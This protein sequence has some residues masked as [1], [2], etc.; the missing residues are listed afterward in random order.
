MNVI[1]FKRDLRVEDN[2]ALNAALSGVGNCL[3]LFIEE[4]DLWDSPP[5]SQ[6]QLQFVRE[7]LAD[8]QLS[9][10]YLNIPVVQLRG[11]VTDVL[12]WLRTEFGKFTLYS[13]Q[14]TGIEWTFERDKNVRKWC[15]FH[16]ISWI[17]FE[18]EGIVRGT[19]SRSDWHKKWDSHMESPIPVLHRKCAEPLALGSLPERF[20]IEACNANSGSY[21]GGTKE[22]LERLHTF[23][24]MDSRL[25]RKGISKPGLSRETCSRLSPYLSWGCL[26]IR[27]VYQEVRKQ[28]NSGAYRPFLSRLR[29]RSH[30]IQKFETEW[31]LEWQEQ[32]PAFA[33]LRAEPDEHEW[34][35]WTT[36]NTGYPLVDACI[37]SLVET[38]YL[39]FRMRAML[40]SFLCH[41]LFRDWRSGAKWM[42][43][44]FTDFEP[45]IHY[46]QFQMQAG[47]T[48]IHTI[49]VYNPVLQSLKQDP[50][51]VFI[52]EWV[53][54]L[55]SLPVPLVHQ[56]WQLTPLEAAYYGFRSGETY[57]KPI[58]DVL[59]TGAYARETLWKLLN[60][61][62]SRRHSK[63][64]VA[65]HVLSK[66]RKHEALKR[67]EQS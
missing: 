45:G 20:C 11:K 22:G 38:G 14:E 1:W 52:R 40:V 53:P 25:Y 65:K 33:G 7:S 35:A 12:D 17:E 16:G 43:A 55:R 49:R 61:G 59:K 15:D 44:Q 3:G 30:F 2:A 47:C 39:N 64:I 4:P 67:R 26:S 37:R 6:R 29:W 8:M 51:A 41:H 34:N 21:K 28:P 58:V 10:A 62:L 5:Y 63:E 56:P 27:Q 48:G 50:D 54:E 18:Q 66:Q 24:S 46:P 42:A 23:L 60:S 31:S 9:L 13:H 36:G 19:G 32:N 57:P